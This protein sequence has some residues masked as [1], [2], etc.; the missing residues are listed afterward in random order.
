MSAW[1][2]FKRMVRSWFG[3]AA[4]LGEDPE[5]ILK[6]NVRDLEAEEVRLNE[7]LAKIRG[8]KNIIERELEKMKTTH[9]DLIA[10]TKAALTAGR[11]DIA[12]NF[13]MELERMKGPLVDKERALKQATEGVEKAQ[14]ILKTFVAE[15]ARKIEETRRALAAK[16]QADWNEKVADTLATFKVGS[17]DQ[18]HEEMIRK[19]EEKAATSEAKLQMALETKHVPE[20]QFEEEARKIQAQETLRQ[21]EL[22]MGL[23]TAGPVKEAPP[24]EREKTIGPREREKA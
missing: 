6:Q 19:L 14:A 11:R 7:E 10:K 24:E 3:W 1:R 16:Q 9:A 13:A 15:K 17:V 12:E 8:Q 5:L 23:A 20:V 4:E 18:T 21:F 22:E 2:R